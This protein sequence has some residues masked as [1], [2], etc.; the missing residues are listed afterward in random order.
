MIKILFLSII[1]S[2]MSIDNSMIANYE[3][4]SFD[5][6]EEVESDEPTQVEGDEANRPPAAII[7]KIIPF[8]LLAGVVV[9]FRKIKSDSKKQ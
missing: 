6:V 5:V 1:V 7:N 9:G 4:D 8:L 2:I 3:K